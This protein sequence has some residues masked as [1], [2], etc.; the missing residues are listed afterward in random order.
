VLLDEF[1]AEK[2][3]AH[4]HGRGWQLKKDFSLPGVVGNADREA[5]SS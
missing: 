5:R 3:G 2:A 4:D 1:A